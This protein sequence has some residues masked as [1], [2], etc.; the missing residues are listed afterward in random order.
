[1][2]LLLVVKAQ[3]GVTVMSPAEENNYEISH[4]HVILLSLK[5]CRL[6]P[7]TEAL[8]YCLSTFEQYRLNQA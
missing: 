3:R 1:M 6:K 5:D 8:H 7:Q 2:K 4:H